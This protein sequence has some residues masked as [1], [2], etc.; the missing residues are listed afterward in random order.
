MMMPLMVSLMMEFEPIEIFLSKV[1]EKGLKFEERPKG[2]ARFVS[3]CPAHAD[4]TPSLYIKCLGDGRVIF[5]CFGG[6]TQREVVES[7]GLTF[8]NLYP[9]T[10]EFKSQNSKLQYTPDLTYEKAL[11]ALYEQQIKRKEKIDPL[12][13]PIYQQAIRKL[14]RYQN[15]S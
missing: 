9:D 10:N 6:C 4:R 5:K 11:V 12:D 3:Q 8:S 1:S 2:S 14:K 13:I 15:E 7:L